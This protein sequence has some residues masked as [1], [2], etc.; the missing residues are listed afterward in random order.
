MHDDVHYSFNQQIFIAPQDTLTLML[1]RNIG[2]ADLEEGSNPHTS[3][4][5]VENLSSNNSK[6]CFCFN[7]D[8]DSSTDDVETSQDANLNGQTE[9]STSSM[10]SK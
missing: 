10:G 4:E 8:G 1:I 9:V 6:T 3:W 7:C 2:S 5:C